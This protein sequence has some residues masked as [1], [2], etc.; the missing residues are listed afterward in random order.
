M[1]VLMILGIGMIIPELVCTLPIQTR[2]AMNIFG[3]EK[4]FRYPR[5]YL[6]VHTL[7]SGHKWR[8]SYKL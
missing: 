3:P 8:A 5:K 6:T 2:A 1:R 7:D 4:Y